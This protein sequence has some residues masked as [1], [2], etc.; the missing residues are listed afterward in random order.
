MLD[1]LLFPLKVL[2]G[3]IE[4]L[5][6]LIG[7][8]IGAVFG[9]IGGFFGLIGGIMGLCIKLILLGLG[10]GAVVELLC[11]HRRKQDSSQQEDFISYYDKNAVQ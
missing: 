10:I 3:L 6:G 11:R 5:F 2:F 9:V 1:I 8:I 4:G 7:G